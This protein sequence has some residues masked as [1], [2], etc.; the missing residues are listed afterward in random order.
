ME[1][2]HKTLEMGVQQAEKYQRE[3]QEI[4]NVYHARLISAIA[5]T[6][7]T[8]GDYL[9]DIVGIGDS[10]T[11]KNGKQNGTSQA[12]NQS[13]DELRINSD[14]QRSFD[15]LAPPVSFIS[16]ADEEAAAALILK[17]QELRSK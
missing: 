4:S 12:L 5:E 1:E 6:K 10:A 8:N 14:D 3:V 2:I 9:P 7:P 11:L 15:S 16:I 13:K 17:N